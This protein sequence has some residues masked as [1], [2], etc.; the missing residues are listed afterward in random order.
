[1]RVLLPQGWKRVSL[2]SPMPGA[3][4][5]AFLAFLAW[6]LIELPA[7]AGSSKHDKNPKADAPPP[8]ARIDTA[9]LDYH[10][11][12]SF[13]LMSRSSSSSLDFIDSEH[14]L[15]TFRVAGLMKRMPD[16]LPDDEDQ[17]IRAVVVHVPDGKVVRSADWRM[18]DRGRYL[19]NLGN[20]KFLLR[21]RDSLKITDASL[22]LQSFLESTT[23]LRLVKL[24]PDARL[25]L[26]ESDLQ[27]QPEQSQSDSSSILGDIPQPVNKD[28]LMVV[29]RI[30]D[31]SVLLRARSLRVTDLPMISEGYVET[32]SAHGNHWM[33]RYRP[34]QGEPTVIGDVVSSCEPGETPLND[35]TV[36]VTAC[37][38]HDEG[39]V[40][41][42]ISLKG[43]TEWTY[44]WDNHYIWPTTATS[45]SG[46]MIAFSTLKV[47]RPVTAYDPFDETEVQAQ[48]VDVLN[49]DTGQLQ[50]TQYA[51]P[52]LSAGQNYA[53]SPDGS[54]F[55]VLRENAIEIYDLPHVVSQQSEPVAPKVTTGGDLM[56]AN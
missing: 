2:S 49:A 21:Q 3:I 17:L 22:E 32:L 44:R 51:T 20:G 1:M 19:W 34:F 12:S 18:H 9:A 8:I 29:L 14:L 45:E 54:R 15:F 48:R 30:A 10:P 26:V 55:A 5:I 52:V 7:V 33:L 13:Y 37:G 35:H 16:C 43:K 25:V 4:R 39:H 53:L 11:L 42:A 28:V 6:P 50:L 27:R 56:G 47:A 41:Q 46:Q 36:I 38:D 31:S 23:A 24:S 40:L